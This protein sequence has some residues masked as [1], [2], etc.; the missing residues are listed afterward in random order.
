MLVLALNYL[1]VFLIL[2]II[3][4]V[5]PGMALEGRFNF[6]LSLL[7][8]GL[9]NFLIRHMLLILRGMIQPFELAIFSLVVNLLMLNVAGGL[10]DDFDL[11]ALSA[12]IFGSVIMSI[13]Q[14]LIDRNQFRKG[15]LLS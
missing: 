5:V 15:T 12:A 1:S 10:I 2:S 4:A 3:V 8:L 6:V 13:I 11:S 14:V 9:V 7:V